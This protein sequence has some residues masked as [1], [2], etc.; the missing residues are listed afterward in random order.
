MLLAA[1]DDRLAAAAVCMGN[2]E[3]VACAN[4]IS[5][6]ATDDAEQNLLGSARLGFDRWDLLYP[7][8]PKPLWIGVSDVDAYGTYSPN[9]IPNGWEEFQKLHAVYK[10]LGQA[11]HLAWY[12]SPL[13]HALG[14]DSRMQI[15][16]FF[17]RWLKGDMRPVEKEPPVNPEPDATL[18]VAES[19]NVVRTFGGHT[20]HTL[21]KSRQVPREPASLADLLAV[22]RPALNAPATKLGRVT[23]SRGVTVELIEV[24][25][26]AHVHLPAWLFRPPVQ[27]MEKSRPVIIALEPTGRNT[28]WREGELY[29]ELALAGCVVCVPD[30]R[31]IGDVAPRN[32]PGYPPYAR[33]HQGEEDYTWGSLILG[34][35]LLGQRVTDILAWV[36]AL[37]ADHTLGSRKVR[38]AALGQLTAPALFAAALDPAIDEL[39]LAAPVLSYRDIVETEN[40]TTPFACFLPGVLLHT[41]LPDVAASLAP[42]PVSLAGT[43]NAAGATVDPAAVHKVYG[44][45]RYL[46]VLTRLRLRPTRCISVEDHA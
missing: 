3:N 34:K 14:F 26:T 7:L 46:K 9:Y 16:N 43:V 13:P 20:P 28:R 39:Y 25:S 29:S 11:N 21:N 32:G 22:E 4:F 17:A 2:T 40:Y 33:E 10:T 45:G 44:N 6:G 37:R 30:L 5:P 36:A 31:C 24:S 42:R 38:V 35:P 15:Y 23:T 18:W 1:A 41:D 8:A 27:A 12:S 19:G